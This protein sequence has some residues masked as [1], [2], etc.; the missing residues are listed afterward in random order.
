[1]FLK[2]KTLYEEK[3]P[4]VKLAIDSNLTSTYEIKVP[5]SIKQASGKG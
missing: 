1:M 3:Y 2:L 4:A 5:I